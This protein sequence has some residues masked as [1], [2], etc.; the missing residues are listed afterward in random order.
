MAELTVYKQ[1]KSGENEC[2]SVIKNEIRWNI[3]C[4]PFATKLITA[5]E[6]L[7]LKT[8]QD[9]HNAA[10][11]LLSGLQTLMQGGIIAEDYD[12]IDFVKRG[13]TIVPSARRTA[14]PTLKRE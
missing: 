5:L 11:V 12:K 9:E 8:E 2:L 4:K 6:T 7:D 1:L 14:A 13:N 3:S 10:N